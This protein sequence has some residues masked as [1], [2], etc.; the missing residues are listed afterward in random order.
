MFPGAGDVVMTLTASDA[1]A[2]VPQALFAATDMAPPVA[3][4]VAEMLAVDDVP[5]HP[6]GSVQV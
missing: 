6:V 3:F 4:G 5:V 2:E 1:E